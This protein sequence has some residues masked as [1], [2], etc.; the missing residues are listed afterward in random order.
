MENKTEKILLAIALLNLIGM[1]I[2]F[3]RT[4]TI[5]KVLGY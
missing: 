5:L 2:T 1:A 4:E 3:I